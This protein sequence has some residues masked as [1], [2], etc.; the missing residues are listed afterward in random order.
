MH[1]EQENE[2]LNVRDCTSIPYDQMIV[3][4]GHCSSSNNDNKN[5]RRID[6]KAYGKKI[7]GP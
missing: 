6:M 7:G 1:K 4:E 3:D 5:E 2:F